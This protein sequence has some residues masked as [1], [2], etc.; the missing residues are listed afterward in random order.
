MPRSTSREECYLFCTLAARSRINLVESLETVG[1]DLQ[2]VAPTCHFAV[3]RVWEKQ[4]ATVAIKLQQATWFGRWA[5]HLAIGVGRRAAPHRILG[6]APP[7]GLRL[8]EALASRF[9]LRNIR[10]LLGIERARWLSTA[11]APIA[12]ELIEWYW[13]LGRPMYEVYGQTTA[14][15]R[16]RSR[17]GVQPNLVLAGNWP[18]GKPAVL[19]VTRHAQLRHGRRR[20]AD[21]VVRALQAA[22]RPEPTGEK[23][24]AV[25]EAMGETID[26][27]GYCMTFRADDHKGV[28]E[29]VESV[30]GGVDQDVSRPEERLL[31]PHSEPRSDRLDATD[32]DPLGGY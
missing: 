15:V 25:I 12:P 23:V 27:F 2:E 29:S 11:A 7:L 8:L 26:P 17:E 20:N 6:D 14:R 10:Q 1:R 32:A 24:I 22:G 5:Y 28:D 19:G 30:W 3:P 21:V 9:V 13:T 4:Y 16:T 31:R 18:E